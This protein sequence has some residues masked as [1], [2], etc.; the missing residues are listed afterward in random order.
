MLFSLRLIA[1]VRLAP[2]PSSEEAGRL[3]VSYKGAPRA[4]LTVEL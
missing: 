2:A 4:A 1:A 3:N